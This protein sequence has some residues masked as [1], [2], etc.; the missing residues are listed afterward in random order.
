L[1]VGQVTVVSALGP[2]SRE[3]IKEYF[4]QTE[5]STSKIVFLSFD[6]SDILCCHSKITNRTRIIFENNSVFLPTLDFPSKFTRQIL[7][8]HVIYL[9]RIYLSMGVTDSL[10]SQFEVNSLVNYWVQYSSQYHKLND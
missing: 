5:H 2:Q 9:K 8:M 10:F 3:C 4:I 7:M 6:Q 1:K